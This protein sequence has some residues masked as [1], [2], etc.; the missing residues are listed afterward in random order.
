MSEDTARK[1]QYMRFAPDPNEFARIDTNAE[2]DD[3]E[4]QYVAL[5]VEEAP[6]G[7]CGVV[8]LNSIP[9]KEGDQFRIQLGM[10]A[11]LRAEIVW[12]KELDEQLVRYGIKFLE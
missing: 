5:I 10:M 4:F 11:P 2:G 6:M 8:G 3:F 12:V 1:R 7:G 9:L